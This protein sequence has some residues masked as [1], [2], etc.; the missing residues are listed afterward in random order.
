MSTITEIQKWWI[1]G[2]G[3]GFGASLRGVLGGAYRP[4]PKPAAAI[5]IHHIFPI[6]MILFVITRLVYVLA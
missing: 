4:A 5:Q 3:A 6:S 1:W 2:A